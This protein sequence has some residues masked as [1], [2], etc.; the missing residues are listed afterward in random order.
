[1]KIV[2][3]E[4]C[5]GDGETYYRRLNRTLDDSLA[6]DLVHYIQARYFNDDLASDSSEALAIAVQ[7][8]FRETYMRPSAREWSHV[9]G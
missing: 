3:N 1:M 7:T 8:W 2:R 6:H 4:I 5:L 9:R